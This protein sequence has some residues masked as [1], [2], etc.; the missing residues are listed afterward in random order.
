[1]TSDGATRRS[2]KA[3]DD[4]SS[5]DLGPASNGLSEC[6]LI[7]SLIRCVFFSW[8]PEGHKGLPCSVLRWEPGEDR[9]QHEQ[10]MVVSIVFDEA[11]RRWRI[12]GGDFIPIPKGMRASST[13]LAVMDPFVRLADMGCRLG[14]KRVKEALSKYID[15]RRCSWHPALLLP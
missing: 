8:D 1:M 7:A 10:I 2:S 4:A 13:D 9:G 12:F 3:A 15:E 14:H 5:D 6:M 11:L